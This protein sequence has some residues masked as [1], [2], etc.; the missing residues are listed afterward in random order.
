LPSPRRHQIDEY[1]DLLRA[2]EVDVGEDATPVWRLP[3]RASTA[4]EI[5]ALL[6]EAGISGGAGVI[7]LHLGAAFGPSKLWPAASFG[8]LAERLA[9]AALV[10]LFLGTA[11]DRETAGAASRASG[12][13]VPSLVGR[14]RPALLPGLLARLS[15]LVSGDTGVAHL[16]AALGVPTVTLFGPTDPRLTA[17]RAKTARVLCHRVSC[18]PC[19]LSACPIDH[20]CLRHIAPEE[21]EGEVRRAVGA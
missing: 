11:E 15:C 21:V 8:R 16:A 14:D 12:S 18:A 13:P 9:R 5:D 10:P 3:A 7:G 1:G 17:P 2:L 19:F 4:S 20:I 6:A